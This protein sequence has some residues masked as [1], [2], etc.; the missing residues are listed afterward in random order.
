MFIK[1]VHWPS[2]FSRDHVAAVRAR[3]HIAGRFMSEIGESRSVP[4]A[5]RR[6][7]CEKADVMF[8]ALGHTL[9]LSDCLR[10]TSLQCGPNRLGRT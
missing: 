4:G 7:F 3:T 1:H 8:E 2:L 5:P 6:P 10:R 9:T